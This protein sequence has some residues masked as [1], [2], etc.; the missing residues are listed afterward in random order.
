MGLKRKGRFRYNDR[1]VKMRIITSAP[2]KI[3][4]C[5]EHFVVYGAPAL[6]I[7]TNNRNR[8]TLR[9]TSGDPS[10]VI[11]SNLG[12]AAYNPTNDGF[13]G[14]DVFKPFTP[15]I[16]HAFDGAVLDESIDIE[17]SHGGAPKGMGSSSSLGVA[18]GLALFA[19]LRKEP[20]ETDL[21][22]CGQLVDEV[23]H[24]GKSSGIDAKTTSR[25]KPQKFQKDFNP[26]RFKFEDIGIEL[27]EGSSLLVVDTF[28]RERD[29][30]SDL[31][32]K[33]AQANRITI[34]PTQLGD[35]ERRELFK[36]YNIIYREFL[37]HCKK[38]GNPEW[39]GNAFNENHKLLFSVTTREIEE[40]R[41]IARSNG[42]YGSKIT[43]AGG[44]GGAVIILAPKD[45]E[46][47]ITEELEAKGY[48]AFSVEIAREGAKLEL[49]L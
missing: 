46:R 48:T 8:I 43:G 3:I 33:F 12:H 14:D 29:T 7:P 25:G 16:R 47:K 19:Y 39:L 45:R 42:A 44:N 18:M 36:D 4:L 13:L 38:E 24:G 34:G 41:A 2:N 15:M 21:F 27:P 22:E 23:A 17:I 1:D 6:A 5:G 30:T 26:E 37:N 9:S 20:N 35:D 11:H 40:A 10:I 49:A 31:I 32:R 28:K